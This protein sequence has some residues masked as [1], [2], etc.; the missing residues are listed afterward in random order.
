M[1]KCLILTGGGGGGGGVR[2]PV[3]ILIIYL[4]ANYFLNKSIGVVRSIQLN[5]LSISS[6]W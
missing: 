1:R 3:T 6:V 2:L 5:H 4:S